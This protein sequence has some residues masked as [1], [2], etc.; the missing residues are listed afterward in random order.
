MK[1]FF[2]IVVVLALWLTAMWIPWTGPQN[3]FA[4][5]GNSVGNKT[6][7]LFNSQA[8]TTTGG[9]VT[10]SAFVFDNPM[11]N[12]SCDIYSTN[13]TVTGIYSIDGNAGT[14][15]SVFEAGSIV[16]SATKT[17]GLMRTIYITEKPTRI[18]RAR[19]T[20]Q[21]SAATTNVVTMNCF[22]VQ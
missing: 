21:S 10:S 9:E 13:A 12:M 16:S 1:R 2:S 15:T 18:F 20:V 6:F 4:D 22:G 19:Y 7:T 8:A 11:N 14:S 17:A 5:N 3:V